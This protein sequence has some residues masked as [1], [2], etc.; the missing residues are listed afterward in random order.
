MSS[1][2]LGPA[3]CLE[4]PFVKAEGKASAGAQA[5]VICDRKPVRLSAKM[6]Q[7]QPEPTGEGLK[8]IFS[9]SFAI[10]LERREQFWQEALPGYSSTNSALIAAS[11]EGR[12]RISIAVIAIAL[13]AASI[14]SFPFSKLA[15]SANSV[16]C[17][18]R[19]AWPMLR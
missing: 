16:E 1:C 17:P 19:S 5:T 6:T 14:A 18:T 7:Q 12:K 13:A 9:S 4:D 15:A 8:R 10:E 2:P 11:R 3:E